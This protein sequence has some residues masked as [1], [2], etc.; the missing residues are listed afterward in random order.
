MKRSSAFG[1]TGHFAY[2]SLADSQP[3]IFSMS[4]S[5]PSRRQ[6]THHARI[7][8]GDN[9]LGLAPCRKAALSALDFTLVGIS[10]QT[11]NPQRPSEVGTTYQNADIHPSLT[12]AVLNPGEM[13]TLT[14]FIENSK[15]AALFFCFAHASPPV[16]TRRPFSF[17]S[18]SFALICKYM[19]ITAWR[20]A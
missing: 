14:H 11:R 4:M 2:P 6:E 18:R 19:N 8:F 5:I 1:W 16:W 17:A 7:V 12:F 13:L 3:G 15:F 9:C 10:Q 20:I